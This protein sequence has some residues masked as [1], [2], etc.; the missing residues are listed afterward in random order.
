MDFQNSNHVWRL[1]LKDSAEIVKNLFLN[2][3][4]SKFYFKFEFFYYFDFQ[5]RKIHLKS[6]ISE[7]LFIG[8]HSSTLY[9]VDN[10]V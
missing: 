4:L 7:I 9:L 2:F 3:R 8:K 10:K 5:V 6:F 1:R